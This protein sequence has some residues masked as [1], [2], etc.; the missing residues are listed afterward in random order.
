MR[1]K[2]SKIPAS[3][4]NDES[5]QCFQMLELIPGDLRRFEQGK[6]GPGEEEP[7]HDCSAL[8]QQAYEEGRCSG[9]E[10]GRAQARKELEERFQHALRLANQIGRTRVVA[11]EEQERD[12]VEIAITIAKK[13]VKQEIT[14]DPQIITRQVNQL[15]EL[16]PKKSLV[17]LKVHPTDLAVLQPIQTS[18]QEEFL[19][20]D[21]LVL[22]PDENIEAG[23]CVIE[24][25]GLLL[26]ARIRQQ[27]DTITR[28]FGLEP[29]EP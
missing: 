8:Q 13:I 2:W 23:G 4:E 5:I 24:Q 1:N 18:L 9:L 28:D 6:D 10:E 15:L 26:D 29:L 27:F 3:V 16:L 25:S 12:V 19:D 11:L 22:D 14:Q 17:T 20:G 21:H 7:P